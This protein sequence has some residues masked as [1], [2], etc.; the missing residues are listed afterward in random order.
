MFNKKIIKALQTRVDNLER[1]VEQ[2]ECEHPEEER[3]PKEIRSYGFR[4]GI[5]NEVCALC[6]KIIAKD[7]NKH[8]VRLKSAKAHQKTIEKEIKEEEREE[9]KEKNNKIIIIDE[10]TGEIK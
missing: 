5:Y 3:M 4:L 7:V 6:G 10:K 1:R 8:E 9:K 2:L